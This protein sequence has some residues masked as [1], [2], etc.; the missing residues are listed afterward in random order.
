M[1]RWEYLHVQFK[2]STWSDST[3]RCGNVPG[4]GGGWGVNYASL[5][6]ELGEQGWELIEV[7]LHDSR[8]YS[9]VGSDFS[10]FFLKRPLA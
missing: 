7:A 3:G 5:L 1:Q 4:P 2:S 9:Q 6:S 10:E 8:Y